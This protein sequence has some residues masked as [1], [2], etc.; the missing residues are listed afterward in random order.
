MRI[1]FLIDMDYFFAA[2]EELRHPEI[3]GK[4]VIVGFDPKG[5][6]GRG[7]VST[8]NYE[9]RKFGIHS[10]MPISMAYKL[11][12]DAI[13]LPIDYAYYE[14]VSQKVMDL[15]KRYSTEFEQVSVDEIYID[16]SDKVQDYSG[17]IKYAN[18]IK[19]NI[20]SELGLP[21]SIGISSN[22]LM[23]K[24]ACEAAKP[25]GVKVIRQEEAK[26]F[27]KN[28]PIGKLHGVGKKTEERLRAMGFDKIGDVAASN[29]S[30]L[31]N[32]FGSLGYEI[33]KNANGIDDSEIS[34]DLEVRSIGRE[35]T[36]DED[37]TDKQL[38]EDKIKGMADEVF[39]EIMEKSIYFK[40]VTIKIRYYDFVE[41]LKSK[42]IHHYS[43][44]KRIIIDTAINLFENF[45]NSGKKV[46]KIGIRVSN[47]NVQKGQKKLQD[48]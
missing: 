27:L 39:T 48:F 28:M 13:F 11:K 31:S 5:G 29:P 24:T 3:K 46:R 30:K 2:C 44:D 14:N 43:N 38:I 22:K 45:S 19:E 33:Y 21:C 4:P 12:P 16:V 1:I 8:C 26:E 37:T 17:A 6:K 36:F 32:A 25:N 47:F 20:K 10:A 34:Q 35:R 40:T 7:V 15:I 23:A 9:A 41:H 18:E 42:S